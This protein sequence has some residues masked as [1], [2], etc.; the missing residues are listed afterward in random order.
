MLA[1]AV[2]IGSIA[3]LYGP[4]LIRM[5]R[6]WQD[7][8]TYSHGW[9]I[10]PIALMLA[11]HRRD[12]LRDAAI[13]PSRA[14][15][16]VVIGSLMVFVAGTLAAELFLTRISLIGVLAGTVLY[17]FGRAHFRILAFPILFLLFMV[18]LPA[19]VFDR[20]A[21]SLQ[22]VASALGEKLMRAGGVAVLR[23]GNVLRLASITLEVDQACSG[24]RSL[25]ALISV[26]TLVG[27]LFEPIAWRRVAVAVAA[28]PLAVALNAVRI[29]LTGMAALR[30]GPAAARGTVHEMT[31]AVV[32]VIALAC[33]CAL[34]WRKR[35]PIA[36][37]V[38]RRL[39]A[40]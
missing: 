32:F 17:A 16:A 2:W 19:I 10:A 34:H 14:G 35:R 40:A 28:V 18:P 37:I 23:D 38:S 5:A 20:A 31:G 21:V 3:A 26:T 27:Y 6:Q 22:L 8:P 1:L 13:A 15:L 36:P 12:R 33:V 11:W 24:I 30:F 4:V 29:G 7:D 25:M 9:V 39:E